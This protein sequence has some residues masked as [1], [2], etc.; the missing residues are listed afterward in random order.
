MRYVKKLNEQ[1]DG[2][3]TDRTGLENL[4]QLINT[5]QSALDDYLAKLNVG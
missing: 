5:A 3:E 4:Q 1:E 2:I